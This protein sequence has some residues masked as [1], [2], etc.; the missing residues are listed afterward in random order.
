[1]RNN[2]DLHALLNDKPADCFITIHCCAPNKPKRLKTRSSTSFWFSVHFQSI[3]QLATIYSFGTLFMCVTFCSLPSQQ[4]HVHH[5]LFRFSHVFDFFLEPSRTETNTQ[6]KE[7][8]ADSR[9]KNASRKKYTN[10]QK[11]HCSGLF[12]AQ[13][14]QMQVFKSKQSVYEMLKCRKRINQLRNNTILVMLQFFFRVSTDKR[15]IRSRVFWQWTRSNLENHR[16][17]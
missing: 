4:K 13:L 6:N 12:F 17:L 2:Q 16:M 15:R 11:W 9:K 10:E 8:H 14:L 1:M 3:V 7:D 5:C